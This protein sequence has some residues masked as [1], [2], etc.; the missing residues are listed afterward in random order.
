[1]NL[2]YSAAITLWSAVIFSTNIIA[3]EIAIY[4][5]VDENNVVHFSQHQPEGTDYSQ[6]T[7]VSSFKAKQK[8]LPEQAKLPSIDEQ[9]SKFEQE[10]AEVAAKNKAIAE[11]NCKAAKINVETLDSFDKVTFIDENGKE[12]TMT[13]KE[14]KEKLVLSKKHI[15]RY[16]TDETEKK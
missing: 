13:Q 8:T 15:E 12:R 5:W 9:L 6:L 1:M 11:K 14:K 2:R 16:C 10:Q 4:R 7:T 3:K